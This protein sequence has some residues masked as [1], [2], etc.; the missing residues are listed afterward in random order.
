MPS[1]SGYTHWPARPQ[2][3]QRAVMEVQVPERVDILAFV[4]ADLACFEALLGGL[5]AG[6]WTGPR[7]GA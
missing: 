1:R 7:R 2:H 5:G 4:A 3:P 6:L